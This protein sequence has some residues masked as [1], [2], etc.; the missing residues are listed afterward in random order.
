M[1]KIFMKAYEDEKMFQSL[2]HERMLDLNWWSVFE[3]HRLK[4]LSKE[5]GLKIG[6]FRLLYIASLRVEQ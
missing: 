3:R 6:I 1:Y 5:S 2:V 4:L